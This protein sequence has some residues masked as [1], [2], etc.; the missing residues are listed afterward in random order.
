MAKR[1]QR[2]KRNSL[3]EWDQ[4]VKEKLKK[5]V[6]KYIKS[7]QDSLR[8]EGRGTG[9][10]VADEIGQGI[11]QSAVNSWTHAKSL[12]KNEY[13]HALARFRR[14]S[15]GQMLDSF[16]DEAGLLASKS[17]SES[18]ENWME[19]W[20]EDIDSKLK[21]AVSNYV[22][23]IQDRL[24]AEGQGTNNSVAEALGSKIAQSSIN[25]W[26]NAKTLPQN[27]YIHALARYRGTSPGAMLDF[28]YAEAEL[29][30]EA[31]TEKDK[32]KLPMTQQL[33]SFCKD[34]SPTQLLEFQRI[35]LEECISRQGVF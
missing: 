7:I 10:G 1:E 9:Q 26:I 4:D 17:S 21:L 22:R 13:I 20:S 34:A 11:V 24:R 2:G 15:P 28:L 25:S 32:S 19:E 35:C 27:E 16:Y 5:A 30:P 31:I 18:H 14:V 6:S 8:S 33:R 23:S 12:P 3:P 29:I